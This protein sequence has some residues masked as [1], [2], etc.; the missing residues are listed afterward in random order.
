MSI[1]WLSAVDRVRARGEDCVLITVVETKGSTPRELGARMVVAGCE[2]HAT[3]GGGNLEYRAIRRAR[4]LLAEDPAARR[5]HSERYALGA[6][7]GQCCGG[8]ARLLFEPLAGG[9][10]EIAWLDGLAA[11]LAEECVLATAVAEDDSVAAIHAV[12][13]A[14]APRDVPCGPLPEAVVVRARGLLADPRGARLEHISGPESQ[15]PGPRVL[16]E[17]LGPPR[18]NLILFGAGHVGQALVAA[19][20]NLECTITWVDARADL[21]PDTDLDRVRVCLSDTPEH[22]VDGAPP[23]SYFLVMTHSH[24]LDYRLCERILARGDFA[25]LGLI[26]SATKRRRL[27]Q[28]LARK[29]VAAGRLARLTCPIGVA[30][31]RGK[32][33]AEIAIAVAAEIL[34]VRDA[35]A[36]GRTVDGAART[37]CIEGS[38]VQ[39]FEVQSSGL[40]FD[41]E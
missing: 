16:Y 30:G 35:V 5:V 34:Q 29:G 13:T 12:I 10:E 17:R 7:L 1:D 3:I 32:Q 21:L 37:K 14:A 39:R 18:L 4:E 36:R 19:L 6:T 26:G 25:Y 41:D 11:A 31:I 38:G 20:R 24:A 23:G 2:T 8:H 33:P 9:A 40:K 28:R 22:Q 27:E 15:G